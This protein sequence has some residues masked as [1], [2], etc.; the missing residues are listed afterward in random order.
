MN[1]EKYC[2]QLYGWL[3]IF[4]EISSLYHHYVALA[5]QQNIFD[6]ITVHFQIAMHTAVLL[7]VIGKRLYFDT[8]CVVHVWP[9]QTSN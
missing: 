3:G 2:H 6:K 1:C 8:V 7:F 9:K 5:Q 4:R